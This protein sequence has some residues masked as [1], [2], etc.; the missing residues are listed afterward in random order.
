MALDV[1]A[2]S[3]RALFLSRRRNTPCEGWKLC[4]A[5]SAADSD[6]LDLFKGLLLLFLTR[7]LV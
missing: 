2:P 7:Q 1:D 5:P 6:A 3:A 4:G